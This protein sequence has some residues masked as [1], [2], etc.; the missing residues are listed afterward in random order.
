MFRWQEDHFDGVVG[1]AIVS[2]GTISFRYQ[3]VDQ[4]ARMAVG[5]GMLD[6]L[7]ENRIQSQQVIVDFRLATF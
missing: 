4:I 6:E 2:C 1:Y 3:H 7:H 5:I